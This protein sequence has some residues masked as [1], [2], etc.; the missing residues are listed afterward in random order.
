M[1]SALARILT[2]RYAF[3]ISNQITIK[4]EAKT[5]HL[6]HFFSKCKSF[7]KWLLS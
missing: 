4:N 5:Y 1:P 3:Y 7:Q 6:I 2:L